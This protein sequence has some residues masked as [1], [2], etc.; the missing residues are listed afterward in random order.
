VHG[1]IMGGMRGTREDIEIPIDTLIYMNRGCN[2]NKFLFHSR[3]VSF[4]V[5]GGTQRWRQFH[6]RKMEM[7]MEVQC[8][9]DNEERRQHVAFTDRWTSCLITSKV[10]SSEIYLLQCLSSVKV[11]CQ[12][13]SAE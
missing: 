4:T 1:K 12:G 8:F 9:N 6:M 3:P 13:R 2:A 10:K 11:S 5:G 7:N